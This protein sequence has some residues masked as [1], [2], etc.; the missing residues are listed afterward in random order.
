MG[1][2]EAVQQ[3]LKDLLQDG[4]FVWRQVG[5]GCWLGAELGCAV[6]CLHVS[7]LGAV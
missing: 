1:S 7:L 6:S 5:A 2:A 4:L 3:G